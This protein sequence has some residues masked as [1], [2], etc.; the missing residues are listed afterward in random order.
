MSSNRTKHPPIAVLCESHAV[1][2]K[3]MRKNGASCS[4]LRRDMGVALEQD[5]A[6][7]VAGSAEHLQ[8]K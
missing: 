4:P 5:D 3:Y 2:V 6:Q 7:H 8:E 1:A